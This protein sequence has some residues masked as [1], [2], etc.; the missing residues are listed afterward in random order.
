MS[1][2][3]VQSSP[4]SQKRV[5]KSS[6]E[7][8]QRWLIS[9]VLLLVLIAIGGFLL[10]RSSLFPFLSKAFQQEQPSAGTT[11]APAVESNKAKQAELE[12]QAKGY[13]LVLQ[14]KPEDRTA[15]QGLIDTRLEL[16]RLGVGSLKDTI[17]PLEKLAKL[18]PE[19]TE[20]AVLLAQTKQQMG[21]LEGAATVYRTIL[22]SKP[23]DLNALDGLVNLLLDQQRPEAAIG[24]LQDTLDNASKL[25]Q[26]K[27]GTIDE[28]SI[29]LMSGRVYAEQQRYD[30]AIAAY[31]KAIKGDKDDFRP[32]LAKAIVL[33]QQGKNDQAQPLFSSAALLAPAKYKDQINQLASASPA[34]EESPDSN[35]DTNSPAPEDSPNSSPDANNGDGQN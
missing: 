18:N 32:V 13:E 31:D 28:V 9:A 2:V 21:D 11:A 6:G 33:R 7:A 27:P 14:R 16:V 8:K 22:E 12:T 23:A 10:G 3:R 34:P 26:I 1:L 5:R 25:N 15:L 35:P 19:Q 24:L 20:Y 30:E 4:V 29:R 17:E